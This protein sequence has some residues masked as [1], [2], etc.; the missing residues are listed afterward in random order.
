MIL[1]R[2]QVMKQSAFAVRLAD[3]NVISDYQSHEE[4]LKT[5]LKILGTQ[6]LTGENS[7]GER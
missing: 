4:K 7:D 1:L 6:E 3:M 5:I 2:R